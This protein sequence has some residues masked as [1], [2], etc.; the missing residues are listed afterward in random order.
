M[1]KQV[2][3]KKHVLTLLW[4]VM[5]KG[6]NK[7]Q[8]TGLTALF[9][10]LPGWAGIRM[11]KPIWILL[12]QKTVSGSGISW[13]TKLFPTSSGSWS[14]FVTWTTLKSMIDWLID[15]CASL[16]LAPNNHAS[17]PLLSFFTGRMPFLPPNQQRQSTEGRA[18]QCH[19]P[20]ISGGWDTRRHDGVY[21]AT[22]TKLHFCTGH[23]TRHKRS[24]R[25]QS[26]TGRK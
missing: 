18:M 1:I 4:I 10:S 14:D 25:P 3:M 11:V 20:T 5:N 9:P 13:A 17:T 21:L 7:L 2:N 16:H 6:N 22:D 23:H 8:H 26:N 19:L 15:W 12:K 24:P